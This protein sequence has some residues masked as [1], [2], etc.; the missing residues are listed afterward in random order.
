MIEITDE[1]LDA[2]LAAPVPAVMLDSFRARERMVLRAKIEAALRKDPI[3]R[4]VAA[5]QKLLDDGNHYAY[6]ELAYTRQTAWMAWLCSK[7]R[8]DD[9]NRKVLAC[10]QGET[11][12]EACAAALRDQQERAAS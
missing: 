10:G 12:A 8:E 3:T 1:M 5:H 2:G 6:F 11:P 9:P 7:P 4:F